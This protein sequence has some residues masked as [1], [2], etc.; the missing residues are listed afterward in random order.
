[1][2][3]AGRTLS[4]ILQLRPEIRDRLGARRST[5]GAESVRRQA[6]LHDDLD[7]VADLQRAHERPVGLDAPLALGHGQRPGQIAI[8][9]QRQLELRRSR[10]ARQGELTVHDEAPV[11]PLD[12][13]RAEGDALSAQDLLVD[14]L[15]DIGAVLVGER[16]GTVQTLSHLERASV[17]LE[18]ERR[19]NT[20]LPHLDGGLPLADVED[21]VMADLLRHALSVGAHLQRSVCPADG[22]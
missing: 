11:L 5:D 15:A 13:A 21:Q 7:I 10:R 8:G 18:P 3:C 14:A 17:G 22:V 2:R 1:M 4:G 6:G 20:V 16:L 9:G 19:G 12:R